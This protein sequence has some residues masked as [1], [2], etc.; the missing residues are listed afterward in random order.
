M[1]VGT[2]AAEFLKR[3]KSYQ[4]SNPKILLVKKSLK[5]QISS[6]E[7]KTMVKGVDKTRIPSLFRVAAVL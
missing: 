2:K 6:I 7:M 4:V 3:I 5:P 1:V